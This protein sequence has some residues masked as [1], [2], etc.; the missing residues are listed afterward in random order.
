MGLFVEFDHS[1]PGLDHWA[2][3]AFLLEALEAWLLVILSPTGCFHVPYTGNT[4]AWV[5]FVSRAPASHSSQ[6]SEWLGTPPG[7]KCRARRPTAQTLLNP[8]GCRLGSRQAPRREAPPR[9]LSP[10]FCWRSL[11]GRNP[12]PSPVPAPSW[13]AKGSAFPFFA[14]S[15]VRPPGNGPPHQSRTGWDLLCPKKQ[16][17]WPRNPKTP[18]ERSW[19]PLWAGPRG[20]TLGRGGFGRR[21]L[22]RGGL[23]EWAGPA[24][25]G[26]DG[27]DPS[28]RGLEPGWLYA[29]TTHFCSKLY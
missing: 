16:N 13:C 23:G 8:R 20:G 22:L 3:P 18:E 19:G 28:F 12:R 21:V 26:A 29:S 27:R 24:M 2:L 9:A 15:P 4:C 17:C 11:Q 6:A 10:S 7:R 1:G 5:S 25:G 14:A